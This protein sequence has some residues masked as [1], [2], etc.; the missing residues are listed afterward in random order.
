MTLQEQM[1]R[2]NAG[3][4]PP[5]V[6]TETTPLA[7]AVHLAAGETWIF[8]WS[9]FSHA[10]LIGE[11]LT[12]VFADGEIVLRGQNLTRVAKDVASLSVKIL[13]TMAPE[14]RPL[15]PDAEPFI[16]EIEV[17]TER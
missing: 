14:Y 3:L 2:R 17:R 10:R 12:L 13:R 1:N 7:V 15:V 9:H 16:R 6:E 5:C 11:T 8:V 4:P